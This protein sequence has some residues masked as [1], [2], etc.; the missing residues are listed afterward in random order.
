[1]RIGCSAHLADV[2]A[3][4]GAVVSAHPSCPDTGQCQAS[5]AVE[6]QDCEKYLSRARVAYKDSGLP[7]DR[8]PRA[9]L[10]SLMHV[11]LASVE[12]VFVD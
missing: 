11:L 9:V 10:A 12:F 2:G 7:A 3:R 8:Q 5:S 4:R 1:M 6:L